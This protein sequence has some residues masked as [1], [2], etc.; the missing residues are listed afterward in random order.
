MLNEGLCKWIKQTLL[1]SEEQNGFCVEKRDEDNMFLVNEMN[2]RELYSGFQ[3]IEKMYDCVNREMLG[4]FLGIIGLNAKIINI[5]H[6]MF[7]DTRARYRPQDIE[8]GWVRST[9]VRQG[10]PPITFQLLYKGVRSQKEKNEC[11]SK[12]GE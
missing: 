3:D 8:T 9:R 11:R 12:C 5:V 2:E 1:L 10:L 4:R 7:V 6:S